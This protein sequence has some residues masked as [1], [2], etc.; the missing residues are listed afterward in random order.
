MTKEEI[1]QRFFDIIG[2]R[3]NDYEP[4]AREIK[5]LAKAF[6]AVCDTEYDDSLLTE[7][8]KIPTDKQGQV[9]IQPMNN[10]AK[11]KIVSDGLGGFIEIPIDNDDGGFGLCD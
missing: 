5:D 3:L 4:T 7:L 6:K 1:K 11:F 10:E 2:E 8:S 9:K